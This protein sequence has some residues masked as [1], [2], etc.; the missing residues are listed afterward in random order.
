MCCP[1]SFYPPFLHKCAM[2]REH[3]H[4]LKK[5]ETHYPKT[6]KSPPSCLQSSNSSDCLKDEK[7]IR[8]LTFSRVIRNKIVFLRLES[9]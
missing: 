5:Q 7:S 8:E 6:T 4:F 3:A 9:K 1:T 2:N